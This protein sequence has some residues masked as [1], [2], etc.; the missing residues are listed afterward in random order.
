[1]IDVAS[2]GELLDFGARMGPGPRANE[3]LEGAV[4]VHNI[5][6]RHSVAYLADEVGMGKTYV[7]LGA[8]ALFRHFQ[9]DFRV[10]VIAPRENIQRKWMKELR[11]FS[12]YNVR[13]PDFRNRTIDDQPGRPLVACDNLVHLVH[14]AVVEPAR[15]FFCRL[16]SFSL[17]LSD[18]DDG[19][20][21]RKLRDALRAAAPWLDPAG[22]LLR[23][24]KADFKDNVA[25]L[26]CCALPT[27]DLVIV[28]EGHNL[29]HGFG[30]NV[31][32]RN[33]VLALAFGH[34]SEAGRHRD[35][36]M[37]GPRAKRV[38]FLSATPLEEDYRHIW[39]QLDIFGLGGEFPQLKDSQLDDEA[40][41]RSAAKFLVRRVTSMD[42]NGEA[43]TKN[44]YRREWRAGG[45][46][47]HDHPI[48][49]T[50]PRQRLVVALVQKKV[51][52]LLSSEK[53]NMSFQ[54]GMLASFESFLETSLKRRV[55]EEE[56]TFD[57]AEQT[58]K[59]EE[60]EGIDV[61]NVN[62][63]ARSYRDTFQAELP[64]P[65]MDAIVEALSGAWKEGRK[66]LVFVRRVAS[67]TEL[68]R[69][70]DHSYDDWL[71]PRLRA[72]LPDAVQGRFDRVVEQ[73][74]AAKS[75]VEASR[76]R[77]ELGVVSH[78][79]DG[80]GRGQLDDYGGTDT[81]FAWFFRGEGPERVISGANI[82]RRFIQAG[83]AYS[84]FFEHNHVADL[85]GVDP[86]DAVSTLATRLGVSD[87]QL[88]TLL[89]SRAVNYLG[90]AKRHQRADRV[91]AFQAAAVE[92]L[93]D[94]GGDLGEKATMVWRERFE[95]ALKRVP[96]SH[97]PDVGNELGVRTFFTELRKAEWAELRQA[98]WPVVDAARV[99]RPVDRFREEQLRGQL[100][101]T[102]ARLG[103]AFIDL[104]VMTIR[105]LGSL[106][107]RA[108]R[109]AE[110]EEADDAAVQ[111]YLE[112]LE[113]QRQTSRSE[114]D[115]GA[116]DEL[117]DVAANFE[118]IL[119]VNAPDAR[120]TPLVETARLFGTQ[121]G[122]QQP[123]A[124]MHG[125]IN[126]TVIQQFRMPGYPFVLITT[127]LLQEGEDLHTFC[128]QVF[129][130]GISWTPSA[131]E[132][133]I[134]RIDRVRSQSDRRLNGKGEPAGSELL[135]VF[136]PCLADT[137]E[138]LQ[139]NRVL[140]RMNTFLR[141]MHQGLSVKKS[142]SPTVD[143]SKE[144]LLTR[145]AVAAIT[146]KLETAFPIPEWARQGRSRKPAVRPTHASEALA[147]FAELTAG[148]EL[149]YPIVWAADGGPGKLM[150]TARLP[151]GREQPFTLLLRS[152]GERLMVRCI[153][154]VGLVE[155][156]D[157]LA[158]V[159]ELGYQQRG[160]FG[161][162]LTTQDSTY[163]LTVETEVTLASKQHDRTRV[164]QALV[165]LLG[166][167]DS[168]E[169]WRFD[170]RDHGL[171][172]FAADLRKEGS[173]G[174]D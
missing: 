60:R 63:L 117:A 38:L 143:V 162:V 157:N 51:A 24:N 167:A 39:N 89:K 100:L 94:V 54:V 99:Q 121:L 173:H 16:S 171:D 147:R 78:D 30:K 91:E 5:L 119:D 76:K 141:L 1:M 84:T 37:Y 166:E 74:H 163:D 120:T 125:A 57:D 134:G 22:E 50:D 27:F 65:K 6:K 126:R 129:H 118:L 105:R 122:R 142:E 23:L 154:P 169:Q 128:S 104:Y 44:Q 110:E 52:E 123:V 114:R 10:L 40:K 160:W 28:D 41:Q 137:V 112:V 82:A 81:F 170:E 71:I 58:D 106:D 103:H 101:A 132:Q 32:A 46:H 156:Q 98:L 116:F 87:H 149:G 53:F 174:H 18:N 34:P 148:D 140:N 83:A 68:K 107:L 138:V 19:T 130:Y 66:S 11:N 144:V 90:K 109:G 127:D 61:R 146:T 168:V 49:V 13:F 15:D 145:R 92:L 153:S 8:V 73:Y 158:D 14:E 165:R 102:V 80:L 70:L 93:R 31:A 151:N 133:R 12:K 96:A 67:V 26:V 95:S 4:A 85:L 135:Q 64:H 33:R 172:A 155:T 97:V 79:E 3:Q 86:A 139:V 36:P 43:R 56:S 9:P 88:R 136:Y 47:A 113:R 72:A 21:R 62:K 150:G 108:R 45:V 48:T 111:A 131:M 164:A 35:F 69:K 115:W 159:V 25:R 29:K 161:V 55:G 77:A 75:E 59:V 2:A 20:G 7:A 42:I 152:D 17:G 124:G